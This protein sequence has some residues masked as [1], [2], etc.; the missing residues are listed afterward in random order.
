MLE[1]NKIMMYFRALVT[2]ENGYSKYQKTELLKELCEMSFDTGAKQNAPAETEG[3]CACDEA[4]YE[5][6]KQSIKV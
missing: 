1:F 3:C 5:V 4:V 2:Y 6:G